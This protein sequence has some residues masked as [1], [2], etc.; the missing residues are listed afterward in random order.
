[1]W[2][3]QV[4]TTC[5]CRS[6]YVQKL[7]LPRASLVQ[8]EIINSV[9]R[10]T[11]NRSFA[12]MTTDMF[13]G[14]KTTTVNILSCDKNAHLVLCYPITYAVRILTSEETI[15]PVVFNMRTHTQ[16]PLSTRN[17]R[18]A[19]CSIRAVFQKERPS[20]RGARVNG[21]AAKKKIHKCDS[22]TRALQEIIYVT[23]FSRA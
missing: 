10:M 15:S 12:D 3:K 23:R 11:V 8:K 13:V 9:D 5:E 1:M 20:P 17:L 18:D 14:I 22:A 21:S 6:P 7:C 16:V 19:P 4:G 2:L